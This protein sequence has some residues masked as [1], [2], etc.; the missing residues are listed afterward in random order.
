VARFGSTVDAKRLTAVKPTGEQGAARCPS[1][2][3]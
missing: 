3:A 2:S 1:A